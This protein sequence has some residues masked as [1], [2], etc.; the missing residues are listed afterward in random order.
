M[1]RFWLVGMISVSCAPQE[2]IVGLWDATEKD[3]MQFPIVY[4]GDAAQEEL[5]DPDLQK[6]V[7]EMQIDVLAEGTGTLVSHFDMTNTDGSRYDFSYPMEMTVDLTSTPYE[8]I[9]TDNETAESITMSC[10]HTQSGLLSCS[11]TVNDPEAPQGTLTFMR[12]Q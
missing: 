11:Y 1:N 9:A 6:A 2:G 5:G 4:E 10:A 7:Q 8:L 12:S 3:G